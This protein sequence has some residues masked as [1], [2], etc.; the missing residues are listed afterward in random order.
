MANQ[1]YQNLMEP[2]LFGDL[3]TVTLASTDKALYTVGDFPP[4]GTQFFRRVGKK[5][6]VRAFGKITTAA[7]PGN[8]TVDIYYGSG[9]DANG[10]LLAASA[11]QA[12]VATQT[13]ISFEVQFRVHCRVTGNAGRL[14]CTGSAFFGTAVIAVGDFLIPAS[15]AV[16]SAAVDLTSSNIIS[17]QAKRS[18][19]TVET[20]T[21][22]DL[23]V[24]ETN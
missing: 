24:Y 22:Q 19:S 3:A 9:A 1:T 2:Y 12:L 5:V 10:V 20:M 14:F 6:Q 16:Q 15:A 4:L 18:G 11:P 23:E 7:T 21:V 8:L 17:L 13:D